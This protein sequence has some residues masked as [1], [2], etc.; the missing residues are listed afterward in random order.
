MAFNPG[1]TLQLSRI[2]KVLMPQYLKVL[3]LTP[4]ILTELIWAF[5]KKKKKIKSLLT[6]NIYAKK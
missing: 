2:L 1:C 3:I 6:D 4:K 5:I